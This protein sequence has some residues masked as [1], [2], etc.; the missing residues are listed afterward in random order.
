M[1]NIIISDVTMKQSG[2]SAGFTLSFRE[3]I[4]LAK[5]KE[6]EYQEEM[7]RARKVLK[8]AKRRWRE[9]STE[10]ALATTLTSI[11]E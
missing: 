6:G 7:E 9:P 8:E 3:K 10:V 5:L 11:R 1:R 4:E 2:K